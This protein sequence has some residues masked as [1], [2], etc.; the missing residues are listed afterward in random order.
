VT[1][2]A[3]RSTVI[4]LLWALSLVAP[5]AEPQLVVVTS[6]SS[7]LGALTAVEVRRLYLGIPLV[8][9]GH[10]IT[11]YR[12]TAEPAIQEVFLQ[13]VVFMSSQAYERHMAARVFRTGGTRIREY[14]NLNRLMEAL[15]NEPWSVTYMSPGVAASLPGIKVIV[16][17]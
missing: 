13:H 5:A 3:L 1:R 12:N 16:R 6:A 7:K 11:P 4:C 9:D 15:N 10:E 8:I 14:A 17:L 2:R